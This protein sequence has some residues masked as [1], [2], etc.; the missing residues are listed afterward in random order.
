M[1]LGV[2]LVLLMS[3]CSAA[4]PDS[5]AASGQPDSSRQESSEPASASGGLDLSAPEASPAESSLPEAPVQ[6]QES[7][8]AEPE[9]VPEEP[10]GST[11]A[12]QPEAFSLEDAKT[13]FA[14]S[15]PGA[16]IAVAKPEGDVYYIEGW[17]GNT[18]YK[19][20]FATAGGEV[21]LDKTIQTGRRS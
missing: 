6:P 9:S 7:A 8:T 15:H 19:M 20:K 1:L 11:A 10:A 2:G 4:G 17:E 14:A 12:P 3:G 13:T 16:E 5:P 21:L 18:L